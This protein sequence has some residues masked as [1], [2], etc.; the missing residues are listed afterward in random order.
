V[1]A[2]DVGLN[3]VG[4][5]TADDIVAGDAYCIRA[6]IEGTH[7]NPEKSWLHVADMLPAARARAARDYLAGR[8]RRIAQDM[9]AAPL[10]ESHFDEMTF[11]TRLKQDGDFPVGSMISNGGR[12]ESVRQ[13]KGSVQLRLVQTGAVTSQHD[14]VETRKVDRVEA[15][16][17]IRYR[18]NCK[19]SSRD[20]AVT[21][22]LVLPDAP[23]NVKKGDWIDFDGIITKAT[24][25]K[26]TARTGAPRRYL[27]ELEGKLVRQVARA[28]RPGDPPQRFAVVV[29]Y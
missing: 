8:Q 14:C 29:S 27:F 16:G 3:L 7:R 15:D 25:S 1:D 10:P 22:A 13:S 6:A 21:Y 4:K 11:G 12:V 19:F 17:R 23:T 20:L 9:A 2:S 5:P 24:L 28:K 18:E 26:S